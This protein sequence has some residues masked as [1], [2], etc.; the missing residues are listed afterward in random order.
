MHMGVIALETEILRLRKQLDKALDALGKYTGHQACPNQ[1]GL[2]DNPDCSNTCRYCWE[3]AL[4]DGGVMSNINE[5]DE[6]TNHDYEERMALGLPIN[7]EGE[8]E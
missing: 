8:S 5:W 4:G 2:K 7:E 1:V 6:E 3:Q